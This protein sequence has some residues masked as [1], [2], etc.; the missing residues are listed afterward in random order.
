MTQEQS[1]KPVT[2]LQEPPLTPEEREDLAKNN[3]ELLAKIE[4]GGLFS[5]RN[6][7]H[8][9]RNPRPVQSEAE[10]QAAEIQKDVAENTPKVEQLTIAHWCGYPTDL[11]RCTPFFPLN[12][13]D[14]GERKFMRNFLITSAGWGKIEYTGPQLSTYE[15]DSLLAI[16]AAVDRQSAE[17]SISYARPYTDGEGQ[18]RTHVMTEQEKAD[19]NRLVA[20]TGEDWKTYTYKGSILHILRLLGRKNPSKREYQRLLNSLELLTVSAV[21]LSIADGKT[22]GGNQRPPRKTQ[23]ANLLSS[24]KWDEEKKELTVTI[25]P[26]FYET[27]LNGRITLVDVTKRMALKGVISK[28]LYRFIQSQRGTPAFAGHFLTLADALNMDREQPAF[29]IRRSLKGA[30]NELI[31]NNVLEKKSC[32]V[33]QDIVKLYRTRLQSIAPKKIGKK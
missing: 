16:L 33:T 32:F 22:K 21:K 14:L 12:S 11:T 1:T 31:R 15:E 24:V 29:A 4:N 25:N 23:M 3:P 20:D 19:F 10:A 26:F 5:S 17:R 27:Y 18:E 28:A 8:C 13:K 30:I 7:L 6:A 9:Y 2:W